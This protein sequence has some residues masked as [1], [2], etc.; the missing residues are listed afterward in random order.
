MRLVLGVTE[1]GD[2]RKEGA[3]RPQV[4]LDELARVQCQVPAI[5]FGVQY[6]WLRDVGWGLG[7]GGW[8]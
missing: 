7:V 4:D 6:I 5:V 8:G 3:L 1:E 2:G